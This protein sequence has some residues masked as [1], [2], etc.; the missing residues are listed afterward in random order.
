M[1]ETLNAWILAQGAKYNVNPYIFGPYTSARSRFSSPLPGLCCGPVYRR[2]Y[3]AWS[4]VRDTRRKIAAARGQAAGD[5][6]I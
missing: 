3:A 6:V 1:L 4:T 5:S 2:A